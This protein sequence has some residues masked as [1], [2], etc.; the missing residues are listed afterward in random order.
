MTRLTWTVALLALAVPALAVPALAATSHGI[1]PLAPKAGVTVPAGK[2]PTFKVKVTGKGTVWVQVCKSP[3]RDKTGLI[4]D[5]LMIEKA[6]RT[7][8]T[9]YQVRPK[10]Y[11]YPGF[12]LNSPGTYYWQAHRI[13]C[14][15]GN[16][17][18]CNQEG[19]IVKIKVG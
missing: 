9:R 4:C 11:N 13:A 8:T 7:S 3:R 10:F 2:S 6:H 5:K 14:E 19:P 15:G 1:T 17:K 16:T 18:D 12:W